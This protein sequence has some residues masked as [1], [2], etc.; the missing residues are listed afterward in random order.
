MRLAG[1]LA[2]AFEADTGGKC[3]HLPR[4]QKKTSR[5]KTDNPKAPS[6]WPRLLRAVRSWLIPGHALARY[7]AACT[8][9]PLPAKFNKM[10]DA[11]NAGKGI[12][13]YLR[14]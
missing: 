3:Q 4:C 13:L 11:L 12:N 2:S 1:R 14:I 10:L 8:D 7:W 9:T 6:C 5:K